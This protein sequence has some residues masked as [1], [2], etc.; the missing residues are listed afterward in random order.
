MNFP[1]QHLR[2]KWLEALILSCHNKN[3]TL[4]GLILKWHTILEDFFLLDSFPYHEDFMTV[5]KSDWS[6]LKILMSG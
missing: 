2:K 3:V 6:I 4:L 1:Q 5:L